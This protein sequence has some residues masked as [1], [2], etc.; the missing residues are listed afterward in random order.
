MPLSL[1]RLR[2]ILIERHAHDL[3]SLHGVSA[4]EHR[5]DVLGNAVDHRDLPVAA[6]AHEAVLAVGRKREPVDAAGERDRG[7]LLVIAAR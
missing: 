7:D 1:E 4:V 3:G 5:D 2:Y 6:H